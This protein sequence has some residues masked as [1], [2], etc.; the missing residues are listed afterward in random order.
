MSCAKDGDVFLPLLARE[1]TSQTRRF[2]EGPE[3]SNAGG[4][5]KFC[6]TTEAEGGALE[7]RGG[8]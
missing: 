6:S 1:A 5:W 4:V 3:L 8:F 7:K 2:D